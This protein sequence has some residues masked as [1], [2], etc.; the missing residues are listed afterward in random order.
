MARPFRRENTRLSLSL[1]AL[2]LAFPCLAADAPRPLR[3]VVPD[4]INEIDPHID[5]TAVGAAIFLNLFEPLF[6][7]DA[8]G[9]GVPVLA[10]RWERIGF[11]TWSIDLRHGVQFHNG[12]TMDS[13]DVV[14]SILRARDNEKSTARVI[15]NTI[16][17]VV[18]ENPYRLRIELNQ[19]DAV[20]LQKLSGVLIVPHDSPDRIVNPI[21]TGPYRLVNYTASRSLVLRANSS[22]WGAKP[23]ENL[24][25]ILFEGDRKAS[26][27]RLLANE[28]DLVTNLSPEMVKNVEKRDDLW[29]DSSLGSAV[30]LLGLNANKPPFDNPIIREAV[31]FALDRQ[32]LAKEVFFNYARPA[33]Q[34]VN[35]QGRGYSSRIE[36]TVRDLVRAK[37]LL[38]SVAGTVNIPFT[39]EYKEGNEP[40][41]NAISRQLNEAGFRVEVKPLPWR[42][43][44]TRILEGNIQAAIFTWRNEPQDAGFTFD[45]IVHSASSNTAKLGIACPE[46]DALIA[47]SHTVL[48]TESRL[49][50]LYSIGERFAERRVL[51]PLVWA[52]D[53]YAVRRDVMWKAL[54]TAEI[55]LSAIT[56]RQN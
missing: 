18:A 17:Q 49:A 53:L 34:L 9:Q 45:V 42:D 31:D 51:M 30:S 44:I 2:A 5:P 21:G 32:A 50:L 41:A 40:I 26:M 4:A 25:E 1:A 54:P 37:A 14:A 36:P 56:R 3:V 15:L 23:S 12:T 20:I 52:M 55:R 47:A 48:D 28:V 13:A 29:V 33:S 19:L 39:L 11:K 8:K 27:R 7:I 38:A 35:S 6:T 46:N 10:T 16:A 24:V 43:L 22:Y